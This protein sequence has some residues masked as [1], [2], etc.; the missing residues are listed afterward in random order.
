M[1]IATYLQGKEAPQQWAEIERRVINDF[2]RDNPGATVEDARAHWEIFLWGLY[3]L[4][5]CWRLCGRWVLPPIENPE[6]YLIRL[7]FRALQLK[8]GGPTK[9]YAER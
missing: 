7:E 4:G 9:F 8:G 5:G 6:D 2:H 1:T 3:A